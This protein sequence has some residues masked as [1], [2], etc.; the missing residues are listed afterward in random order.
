[1]DDVSDLVRQIEEH[2]AVVARLQTER[3]STVTTLRKD[4]RCPSCEGRR[5]LH[6]PQM[7]AR[8]DGGSRPSPA[9]VQPSAWR[10]AVL[11]QFE[12]YA[13]TSCGWVEWYVT[14]PKSLDQ[15]AAK[16][17]DYRI[18]DATDRGKG[19]TYR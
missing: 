1:M 3:R 13:C 14:D 6:A 5:F 8:A 2:K 7:L 15:I 11:G 9:V 10:R 18:V 16:M 17:T 12:A 19:A 4:G